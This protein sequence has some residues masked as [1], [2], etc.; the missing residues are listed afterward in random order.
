M[1]LLFEIGIVMSAEPGR[2]RAYTADIRWRIIYQRM[3]LELPFDEKAT[4]LNIATSTAHQIYHQFELTGDIR[5]V[6]RSEPRP[7]ARALDE[8][9]GVILNNP[10]LYLDELC[11]TTLALTDVSV[12]PSTVCRMMRRYGITRKC[13]RQVALQ[14]CDALRGAFMAHCSPFARNQFVWVD[15]TGSDKRDH[16][17][18]YSYSIRGTTP[19]T[20]RLFSRGQ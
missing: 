8:H 3:A 19:V 10:T 18:R 4:H 5:P 17:R 7:E 9:N 14:R 16:V 2:K 11:Q 20:H 13:V 1:R 6:S 15:E 12:S